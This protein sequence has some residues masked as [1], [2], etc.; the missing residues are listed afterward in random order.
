MKIKGIRSF[1]QLSPN[2][3]PT[4]FKDVYPG[5]LHFVGLLRTTPEQSDEAGRERNL[6]YAFASK[7]TKTSNRDSIS[8]AE[9]VE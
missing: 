7:S 1:P 9:V 4:Q 8:V 2:S 6:S 3:S 5:L